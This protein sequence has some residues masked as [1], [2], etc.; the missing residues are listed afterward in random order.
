MWQST[1]EMTAGM[2]RAIFV[3][4]VRQMNLLI[5]SRSALNENEQGQSLPVLIRVYQLKDAKVFENAAYA[6]LI[7]NDRALLRADLLGS[8]EATLAPTPPCACLRQWRAT[9]KSWVLRGSSV[10]SVVPSGNW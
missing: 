9:R 3:T 6:Q 5:E 7:D 1:K 4:K 8:L 10:V 2:T